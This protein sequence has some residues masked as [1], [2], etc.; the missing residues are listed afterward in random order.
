MAEW[1]CTALWRYLILALPSAPPSLS[2]SFSLS[3]SLLSSHNH[4]DYFVNKKGG[5]IFIYKCPRVPYT[6]LKPT[7]NKFFYTK[8]QQQWSNN[9]HNKLFQIQPTLGE[10]RPASRKSRRE[11][12]VI[13]RL[14]IGHTRLTHSFILI[15][16]PQPQYSTCLT[17]YTVKYIFIKC[18][19]FAVTRKRFFKVNNLTDLFEKET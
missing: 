2:L 18:R 9:I 4:F 19:T 16:E 13:S 7:S 5:D 17:T 10:W 15:H 12:V 14:R 11:Q 8:W 6:D 3:L 1:R